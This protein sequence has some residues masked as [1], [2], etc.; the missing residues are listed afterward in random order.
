MGAG[1]KLDYESSKKTYMVTVTATDPSQATA[2]IEVTIM[3]MDVN[4]APEFTTEGDF[5]EAFRGKQ[6]GGHRGLQ[7]AGPGEST[8]SLLCPRECY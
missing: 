8:A 7:R 5:T 1:T 6:H 3:V 2:T 4:E